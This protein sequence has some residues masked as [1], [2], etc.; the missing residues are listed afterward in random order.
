MIEPGMLLQNRYQVIRRLGEGGFGATFEVGDAGTPKVLKVMLDNYPKA[1][2][3][4]QREAQVLRGLR[5]PGIPRVEADGYFTFQPGDSAEPLHCLVM[6]KIEGQN[7]QEWLRDNQPI[8]QERAID[9]LK[10]LAEILEELHQQHYFHRDIKPDNIMLKPDGQLVLIDFGAVREMTETYLV[11]IAGKCQ[12][13]RVGTSGYMPLEQIDGVA[14]PQ[15]DFYALGRTFVYLLTGKSPFQLIDSQTGE[16]IWRHSAPQ[17]SESLANLID[18]LMAPFPGNRPPNTQVILQHLEAIDKG[19]PVR[20]AVGR[21]DAGKKKLRSIGVKIGVVALIL[22]GVGGLWLA[23]PKIAVDLNEIGHENYK[24]GQFAT[25]EFYFRWA[26]RFNP[27]LRMAHY[28][29]G[30]TC[31]KLKNYDCA[32]SEHRLAIEDAGN[33]AA[34]YALNNLGRLSLTLDKDYD[35]ALSLLLQGLEL[36][37]D[38]T[39]KSDLHKNAGWAYLQKSRYAEANSHLQK[40]IDINGKNAAAHCL[41]AQ[42]LESLNDKAGAVGEW[43]NCLTVD[44]KDRRPEVE[45]WRELAG[46]RLKDK[47]N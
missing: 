3:L 7:L 39:L 42:V 26:I 5:H 22:L 31:E 25:A 24:A 1:V 15:S 2:S 6:E 21:Q 13:T 47:G 33:P 27:R 46:Q 14:L 29:L 10:Q 38:I 28:N 30:A 37:Q 16:L 41:L 40:A 8:S 9:W 34:P 45:K 19:L 32:R 44:Q 23:T 20:P 12:G 36:A 11:K 43:K 35:A 18:Y 17:V 4:F